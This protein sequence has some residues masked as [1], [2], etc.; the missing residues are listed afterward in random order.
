MQDDTRRLG[1]HELST[2]NNRRAR[3]WAGGRAVRNHNNPSSRCSR[4]LRAPLC[5]VA[6]LPASRQVGPR[7]PQQPASST[8]ADWPVFTPALRKW[9]GW[10]ASKKSPH[11][12]PHQI[13][14]DSLRCRLPP[15]V[16]PRGLAHPAA[17]LDCPPLAYSFARASSHHHFEQHPAHFSIIVA[18][19]CDRPFFDIIGIAEASRLRISIQNGFQRCREKDN[20]GRC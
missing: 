10:R 9:S 4:C 7:G 3:A 20:C 1:C 15:S 12:T 11:Q 6:R 5:V 16:H 2:I 13:L 8:S 19:R 14:A 17:T 18:N